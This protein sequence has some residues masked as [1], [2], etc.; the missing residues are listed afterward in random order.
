MRKTA[1]YL[2]L[3]L[4]LWRPATRKF[5]ITAALVLLVLILHCSPSALR[6]APS[7]VLHRSV[8]RSPWC[9]IARP[10][11]CF[12]AHLPSRSVVLHRP[13]SLVFRRSSPVAHPSLVPRPLSCS[14]L[15]LV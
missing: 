3:H 8:S 13:P 10:P 12:V 2:T 7:L 4:L 6:H 15:V 5:P 9:S 1:S 14:S 11:S